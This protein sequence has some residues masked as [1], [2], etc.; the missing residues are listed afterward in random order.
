MQCELRYNKI[1]SEFYLLPSNLDSSNSSFIYGEV[2]ARDII[3]ILNELNREHVRSFVDI[4]SGCGKLVIEIANEFEEAYCTGVEIHTPRYDHSMELLNNYPNI[5]GTTEFI[6]ADF[7]KVYF[8]N[9]DVIY[10]CNTIFSKEDNKKLYNK[11]L[12]EFSGYV[13]LFNWDYCMKPYLL[14]SYR[15]NT[16]WEKSVEIFVFYV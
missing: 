15:V 16:S 6:C 13:I 8:G 11:I 14:K 3:Y 9:Y 4:G 5:Q 10:C 7:Q 1:E 12:R 2:C